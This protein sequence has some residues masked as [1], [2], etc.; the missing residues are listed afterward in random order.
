MFIKEYADPVGT[1]RQVEAVEALL[2]TY[3]RKWD[4]SQKNRSFWKVKFDSSKITNFLM[5]ALDDFIVAV[6][7]SGIL[8]AD[9]KATVLLATSKLYD[10]VVKEGMPVWLSPFAWTVKQYVIYVLVSN[11]ID[12]VVSKYADGNWG[13]RQM[14]PWEVKLSQCRRCK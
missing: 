10:Y 14:R 13:K 11:A 12:W 2:Q 5:R 3:M 7:G 6:D 8:G 1:P 4:E 9:K